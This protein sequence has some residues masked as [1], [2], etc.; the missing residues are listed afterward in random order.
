MVVADGK[1]EA[2]DTVEN[3]KQGN[4]YYRHATELAR[5]GTSF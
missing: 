1:L 2:F 4:A 3:L 5:G